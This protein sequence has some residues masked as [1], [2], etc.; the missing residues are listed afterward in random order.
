MNKN[1]Q[2]ILEIAILSIEIGNNQ[3]KYLKVYNTS[4]PSKLAYNFCLEYNLDYESLKK[5]TYEIKNLISEANRKHQRNKSFENS[6]KSENFEN[7]KRYKSMNSSPSRFYKNIIEIKKYNF[8]DITKTIKKSFECENKYEEKEEKIYNENFNNNKISNINI[9]QK[10]NFKNNNYENHKYNYKNKEI[11]RSSYLLPTESSKSKVKIQ[12]LKVNNSYE[13]I[14]KKLID[15]ND[16]KLKNIN[17]NI[18]KKSDHEKKDNNE[19]KKLDNNYGVKLYEKGM[20][21]KKISK[22][23]IINE[24][25]KEKAKELLECTFKPKINGINIKCFKNNSHKKSKIL[26]NSEKN[27]IWK[28]SNSNIYIHRN[29]NKLEENKINNHEIKKSKRPNTVRNNISIFER[30]YSLKSKKNK[31]EKIEKYLF[32]PKINNYRKASNKIS[33]IDKQKILTKSKCGKKILEQQIYTQYD[34]KSG[35]ILSPPFMNKS[36]KHTKNNNI[37]SFSL[38]KKGKTKKDNLK[39]FISTTKKQNESKVNKN[40]NNIFERIIIKSFR[41]IFF[42]LDNNKK[43]EISL[44]NYNTKNLPNIIKKIIRPILDKI[45]FKSQILDKKKFINECIKLYKNLDYYSK[46]A[47]YNFSEEENNKQN[48]LYIYSPI[49]T[50]KDSDKQLIKFSNIYY[51]IYDNN[52]ENEDTNITNKKFDINNYS[53]NSKF[54]KIYERLYDYKAFNKEKIIKFFDNLIIQRDDIIL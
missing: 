41:K 51:P 26:D 48:Y 8:K 27:Q 33:F 36:N 42:I 49:K 45:D 18:N 46:R 52:K 21:L 29:I 23:K 30:L 16:I 6:K 4:I 10:Q 3:T 12:K 7:F 53:I 17:N 13:N 25:N 34:S 39:K 37:Y 5:L 54:S 32:K 28:N 43:G 2:N 35:Q 20:E 1:T 9:N 11:S 40:S 38:D 47:I 50:N 24:I 22:E 14:N 15:N 31:E 44:F 19:R